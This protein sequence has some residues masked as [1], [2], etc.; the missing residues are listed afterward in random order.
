MAKPI[1]IFLIG[2]VCTTVFSCRDD[3][4]G[5]LVRDHDFFPLVTGYFQVYNV[6]ESRYTLSVPETFEYQLKSVVVD[7]FSNNEGGITYVIHRSRRDQTGSWEPVE[8]WSAKIYRNE[9]V[10][11]EG[12]IPYVVLNFPAKEGTNWNGNAYNDKINPS[13]STNE[14]TYQ[15][16][17]VEK[18]MTVGD[19]AFDDC[20]TVTQ[21]DNEEF[22]VFNDKRVEIYARNIGLVS[23]EVTQL[24]YCS[25]SNC[26]GQQIVEE[27]VIY[28]QVLEQYGKE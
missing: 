9:A 2:L 17:D 13:T 15:I 19:Q 22:I 14:D 6:T 10:V 3:E 4:S 23:K 28:K 20:V 27:G 12:N 5:T 8:T 18:T 7:S 24:K 21:E 16:T 26:I 11:F 25:E 1:Q